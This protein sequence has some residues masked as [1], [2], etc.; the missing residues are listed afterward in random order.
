VNYAVALAA[1]GQLQAAT[2]HLRQAIVDRPG[3]ANAHFN[4]GLTLRAAGQ[5][6]E[7]LEHFEAAARLRPEMAA[8][9][10]RTVAGLGD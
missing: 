4:L 6:R 7:A 8:A 1:G 3:F 2:R 5:R 9:I 10:R